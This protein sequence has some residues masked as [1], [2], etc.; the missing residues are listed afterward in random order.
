M[1]VLVIGGTKF[2]GPHLTAELQRRG[3]TVT[4]FNRGITES[5]EANG[6]T[7]VRGDR[8][9]DLD[10]LPDAAW[11]AV[12]DMCGYTPDVVRRSAE[13][14]RDARRYVF[15]S[16]IS[17]YDLPAPDEAPNDEDL[18]VSKLTG[19]ADPTTMTAETY[20]P[21]KALC[22]D[23]VRFVYG[24]RATIL[25]PGLIAGQYDPTDRFTYWPV[26]AGA[27]GDFL[28]PEG[29]RFPLQYVDA[30]DLAAFAVTLIESQQGGTYNVVTAPG[31]C[32][33]GELLDA[34]IEQTRSGA[35]P[36]WADAEFLLQHDIAPWTDL[37]LWIPRSE[38][39]HQL[40]AMSNARAARA[41][42]RLR[43][44]SDTVAAALRWAQ[45]KEKRF[46][47]LAAGLSPEREAEALGAFD[48]TSNT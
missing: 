23:E 1:N 22:E 10:R 8:A 5:T 12:V 43:N 17:V 13:K 31:S 2:V 42:L 3:H 18:A 16:S 32:D 40:I 47:N 38:P 19:D 6:V 46:G 25:R 30:R 48:V 36:V 39:S 27:G 21:L 26:R 14:L 37:P 29:P 20:G 33:F 15:V 44:L 34:C 4:L 24:E 11:D 35:R 28:A 45:T 9:T 41:G 7:T